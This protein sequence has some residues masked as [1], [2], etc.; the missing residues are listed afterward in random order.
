M[1]IAVIH[2]SGSVGGWRWIYSVFG[3]I[4]KFYPETFITIFYQE[5]P[6]LPLNLLQEIQTIG[7]H[8]KKLSNY[9]NYFVRKKYLGIKCFDNLINH[10]RKNNRKTKFI[11][12][13]NKNFD[14]VFNSWPYSCEPIKFNIPSF[15]I[16][17]DFIFTHFFGL[18]VGNI[19]NYEWYKN[20]KEHLQKYLNYGYT[21]VV[22]SQFIKQEFLR[23]F[24]NY[25]GN[26]HQI[27]IV[28]SNNTQQL[29]EA[30]C[31]NILKKFNIKDDYILYPTNSMHHKNMEE[32]L[33]AYYYVKQKYPNIKMIV[34]GYETQGIQVKMNSPY[35]ADHVDNNEDYDIKSLG[36]VS[37]KE[38]NALFLKSKLVVNASLCEAA[39]GSG[40]DAWYIGIPTAISD[41]PC[42]KEQV[43]TYGVK[44]EFFNPK[45]SEDIGNAILRILD[46]PETAKENAENSYKSIRTIYTEK[47]MAKKFITIFEGKINA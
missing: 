8:T 10:I 9:S 35:Y 43:E 15:F 25:E 46:N 20:T 14:I 29:T 4:K 5:N 47:L 30:D 42:Y 28:L 36:L 32:V 38:L 11:D 45:N 31:N 3:A 23:T 1:K 6:A 24:P 22:T 33:T 21:P 41:I 16:P 2:D 39:C 12:I 13:I 37:D 44:T 7:I 17:H 18:H 26:I 19:Y 27:M 34:I 40:A